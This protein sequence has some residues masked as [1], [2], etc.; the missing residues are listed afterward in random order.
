M[1]SRPPSCSTAAPTKRSGNPGSE[2]LPLTAMAL[3]P[4]ATI[5][6]ATASPGAVSRSLT[7]MLAPSLASFNAMARPMPRPDPV[8]NAT[9]PASLV[10]SCPW[11]FLGVLWASNGDHGLGREL[12][13]AV[14]IF[15]GQRQARAPLALVF[16][17]L[18]DMPLAGQPGAELGDRGKARRERTDA[19]RRNRVG[20]RLAQIGHD[21]HAVAEHIGKTRR[22]GEI[23]IDM[24]RVVIARSAAIQCQSVPRD[25]RKRLVNDPFADGSGCNRGHDGL[26][27]R[28]TIVREMS[29]TTIPC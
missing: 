22:A 21:Q 6:A 14:F 5:S 15:G 23:Q 13:F 16:E 24:D 4:A 19:G 29:A 20:Q 11:D 26:P 3:P 9:F 10:I 1:M 12:D 27:L 25:R 2:T 18:G 28:T 7:T 8:I 17:Q